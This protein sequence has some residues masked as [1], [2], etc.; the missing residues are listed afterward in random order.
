MKVLVIAAHP[1]DEIL[2]CG[3]TLLKHKAAGDVIDVCIVTKGHEPFWSDEYISQKEEE[4]VKVDR[5][6]GTNKRYCAGFPTV[7]LNTISSFDFN[8]KIGEIINAS[9]P[10]IIYTHHEIDINVDHQIVFNSVMVNTRPIDKHIKVFCYE[11]LSSTEWSGKPFVPNFYVDI[12]GYLEEKIRMFCQYRSEVKQFPHPR[13]TEGIRILA[14][15][16]GMDICIKQAEAFKIVRDYW[17]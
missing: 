7:K 6:L 15:K 17:K 11:T 10:D 16:R 12:E 5:L 8:L 9:N 3:G 13:S 1:D 14:A 2:G 4:A